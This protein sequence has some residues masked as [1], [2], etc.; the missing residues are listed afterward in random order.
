MA[1]IIA[2]CSQ[3]AGAFAEGNTEDG[4][5]SEAVGTDGTE[6]DDSELNAPGT[7]ES[8]VEE[9]SSSKGKRKKT[10]EKQKVRAGPAVL[11]RKAPRLG[12]VASF[13]GEHEAEE[14]VAPN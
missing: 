12:G 13:T 8:G 1:Y 5:A 2:S 11:T 10:T 9:T 14:E 6:S 3:A 4:S 7:D